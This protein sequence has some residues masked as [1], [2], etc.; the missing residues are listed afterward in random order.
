MRTAAS[1]PWR[2]GLAQ[3]KC[4]LGMHLNGLARQGALVGRLVRV[5]RFAV[6]VN[7]IDIPAATVPV[8]VELEV[9]DAALAPGPECPYGDTARGRA[10]QDRPLLGGRNYYLHPLDDDCYPEDD[11]RWAEPAPVAS[12]VRALFLSAR[13]EKERRR[14]RTTSLTTRARTHRGTASLRLAHTCGSARLSTS[15]RRRFQSSTR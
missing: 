5:V 9:L 8:M 4:L 10:V 12:A 15:H 3:A 6:A 14:S 1:R 13:T 11:P 2:V 7:E